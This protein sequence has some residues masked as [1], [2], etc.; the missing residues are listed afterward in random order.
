MSGGKVVVA[1][2]NATERPTDVQETI[3]PQKVSPMFGLTML[4]AYPLWYCQYSLGEAE[5][6]AYLG[7]HVAVVVAIADSSIDVVAGK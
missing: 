1:S 4:S 6:L 2:G 3:S 7:Q 5:M